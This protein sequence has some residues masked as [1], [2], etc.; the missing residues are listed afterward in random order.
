VLLLGSR[1]RGRSRSKSGFLTAARGAWQALVGK[2]AE[3]RA[4][5][6]IAMRWQVLAIA[7]ACF[8]GGFLAGG[9]FSAWR[10]AGNAGLQ[11]DG[12]GADAGSGRTPG[13]IGEVATDPLSNQA[14]IVS[15]YQIDQGLDSAEAKARAR[16]LAEW[17]RAQGIEKARP[18]EYP[19]KVGRLWVVAVYY[20]G[21]AELVRTRGLLR[22]LPAAPD[23]VFEQLRNKERDWPT[24]WAIR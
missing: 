11:A 17:L 21:E 7:L 19:T 12:D 13:V 16:S 22:A 2:P 10:G 15:A 23:A 18:Y 8:A 4:Q 20:D 3:T 1:G 24:T 9:E 6:G 14:F 5:R